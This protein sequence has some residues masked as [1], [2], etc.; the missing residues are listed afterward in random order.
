MSAV[1]D[2][3]ESI[4]TTNGLLVMQKYCMSEE[5]W[6]STLKGLAESLV[7]KV[8]NFGTLTVTECTEVCDVIN[9]SVLTDCHKGKL[10]TSLTARCFAQGAAAAAAPAKA[11]TQHMHHPLA[12]FTPSDWVLLDDP[13]RGATQK[14]EVVCRRMRAI[15]CTHPDEQSYGYLAGVVAAAHCP[16]AAK[17]SLY[18]LV[19]ETKAAFHASH[20]QRGTRPACVRLSRFPD[21][22]KLLPEDVIRHGY[23]EVDDQPVLKSIDGFQALVSSI[24][25][26]KTHRSI[27]HAGAGSGSGQ[28]ALLQQQ[29]RA[30]IE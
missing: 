13:Y 26:R 1:N 20:G 30:N 11:D 5:Q 7:T 19:L 18:S 12:Y 16:T 4:R 14:V 29:Q 8:C 2:L 28:G 22:P 9:K 23:P 21:E 17:D 6:D 3:I 10:A 25:L 27:R 15:G 24:P